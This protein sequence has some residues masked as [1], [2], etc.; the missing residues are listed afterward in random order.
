MVGWST[1][2]IPFLFV[3]EPAL[4]MDG[5]AWRRSPGTWRA[6][7]SASMSAPPASSA[8]RFTPLSLPMRWLYGA[9]A[10]AILIP[11]NA[12]PGA[13]LLDW[14][15]LAWRRPWCV[16]LPAQPGRRMAP[17]AKAS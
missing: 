6:T 16:R 11:P 5:P 4:L 8:L 14:V 12:F 13:D 2:F 1:F 3:L 9:A 17:Q 10:L 15:G 7:C